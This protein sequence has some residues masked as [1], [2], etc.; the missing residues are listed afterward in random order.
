MSNDIGNSMQW[1]QLFV[2]VIGLISIFIQIGNKQGKQEEKNKNLEI[3]QQLQRE[4]IKAIKDDI[5]DI[6]D[7]VA[8]I[9]GKLL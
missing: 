1:L 2:T 9:K 7:D 4:E 3:N 8:Y 6:K 5:S